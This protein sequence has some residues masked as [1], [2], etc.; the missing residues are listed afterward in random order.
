VAV[1][2]HCAEL[3]RAL[4]ERAQPAELAAAVGLASGAAGWARD[5]WLRVT[6]TLGQVTSDVRGHAGLEVADAQDLALWTGRLALA[7]A[8]RAAAGADPAGQAERSAADL[9]EAT[10]DVRRVI[11]AVHYASDAMSRLAQVHDRQAAMAARAGRFLSPSWSL[12]DYCDRSRPYGPAP[13]DRVYAVPSAYAQARETSSAFELRMV[14][15]AEIIRLRARSP[16]PGV[17]RYTWA[18]SYSKQSSLLGRAARLSWRAGF[19]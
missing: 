11:A 13:A 15:G 10:G 7:S 8:A 5:G 12:P 6:R 14:E 19:R 4:G 16:A 17:K 9:K 2:H 3:L 18:S 1:N